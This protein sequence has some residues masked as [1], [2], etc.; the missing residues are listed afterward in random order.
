MQPHS[1]IQLAIEQVPTGG[2]VTLAAGTYLM[3]ATIDPMGK[4]FTL[5]GE[6]DPDTGIPTSI[7]DG[8]GLHRVLQCVSGE[9]PDTVFEGLLIQNGLAALSA[10][11]S[12]F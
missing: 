2:M 5:Q 11:E 7:L 8:Q 9:G 6:I 12:S 4:A 10:I 3:D 1:A